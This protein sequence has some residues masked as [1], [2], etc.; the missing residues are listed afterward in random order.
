M[1]SNHAEFSIVIDQ[2]CLP[3]IYLGLKATRQVLNCS[4]TFLD[5]IIVRFNCPA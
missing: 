1:Q 2:G 3:I 4:R 5:V